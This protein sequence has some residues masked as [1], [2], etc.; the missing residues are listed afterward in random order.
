M[1]E[2]FQTIHQTLASAQDALLVSILAESGSAP[3]GA[4]AHMLVGK[5]GRLMGSI[6]GGAMEHQ[7]VQMAGQLLRE[8]RSLL[9]EYHLSHDLDMICGG[10]A[11]VFFQYIPADSTYI[12]EIC[13]SALRQ[14]ELDRDI[15]LITRLAE[16]GEWQ[17]GLF[18]HEEGLQ[19]LN[20]DTKA[21]QSCLKRIPASFREGGIDSYVE[22][23][24]RAGRVLVFGCGHVAQALTPLLAK[25]GFSCWLMD[26]RPEFATTELF[27]DANRVIRVDYE[28]IAQYVE[29]RPADFVVVMT[30]GHASDYTVQKQSM[31]AFPAYIGVIGSKN[32]VKTISQRLAR[33]GYGAQEIARVYAPIGLPIRAETPAEIAVSIVAQLIQV[34][35]EMSSD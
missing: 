20:L 24:H 32:K 21:L 31:R 11:T 2:L 30:H 22:P 16:D 5:G 15:W 10:E 17:M 35:A 28:D 6:G 19:F 27:P 13:T 23:I 8:R 25:V 3:R 7:A 12:Q 34:R 9:K 18:S 26:D 33:E 1:Q 29:I 14:M 4:G